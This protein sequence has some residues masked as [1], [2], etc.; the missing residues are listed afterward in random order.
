MLLRRLHALDGIKLPLFIGKMA[1][2][3]FSDIGCV[4]AGKKRGFRR[5]RIRAWT[6]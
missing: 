2:G 5:L 4:V 3:H 6:N 1:Y